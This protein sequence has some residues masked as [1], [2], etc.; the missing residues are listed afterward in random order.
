VCDDVYVW[1]KTDE[2]DGGLQTR[3]ELVGDADVSARGSATRAKRQVS[4]Q[5][6][7]NESTGYEQNASRNAGNK[8]AAGE[9]TRSRKAALTLVQESAASD[10][11][12]TRGKR[13]KTG[14]K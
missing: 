12:I 14:K 3:E 1:L 13:Q 7:Q 4:A 11:S 6:A 10:S 2:E 9:R 5:A 8:A